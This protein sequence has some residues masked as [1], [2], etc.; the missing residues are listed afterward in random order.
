M[1]SAGIRRSIKRIP[2]DVITQKIA[3]SSGKRKMI[4]LKYKKIK[5]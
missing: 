4:K 2:V 3:K 1:T 5:K